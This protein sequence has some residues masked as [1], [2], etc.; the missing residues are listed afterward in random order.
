MTD[1][2]LEPVM[3][4]NP[5]TGLRTLGPA[6]KP[7]NGGVRKKQGTP[8]GGKKVAGPATKEAAPEDTPM[9]HSFPAS[10]SKTAGAQSA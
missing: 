1:S 10:T 6:I 4:V 2:E 9:K 5:T 3:R 7:K 8:K